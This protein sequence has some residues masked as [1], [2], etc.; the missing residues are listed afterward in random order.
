MKKSVASLLFVACVSS[1]PAVTLLSFDFDSTSPAYTYAYSYQETGSSSNNDG[2]P[3]SV[4]GV[5]VGGTAGGVAT[6]DTTSM[7]GSFAGIGYGFGGSSAGFAAIVNAITLADFSFSLAAR[8]GGLS[9]TTTTLKYEFKFEAP[10]GTLGATDGQTDVL[11]TLSLFPSA[12][13]TF[14][15]TNNTLAAWNIENGSLAQL[16]TN[17]AA[18]NNI[19]F[20][21]GYDAGGNLSDFGNDANNSIL[22]DNYLLTVIPEPSSLV[23]S[24]L[25]LLGLAARRKRSV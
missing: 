4:A 18:L 14:S 1:A 9:S 20:N 17:L 24:A 6:F 7:S 12:T 21:L 10:D 3:I 16:K 23:I 19:N 2:K 22:A 13:S 25:G 8:A 5:G 11:L 15:V